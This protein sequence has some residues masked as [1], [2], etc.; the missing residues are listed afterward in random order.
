[1]SDTIPVGSRNS[2]LDQVAAKKA[3]TA[4]SQAEVVD[5]ILTKIYPLLEQP[6]G[7][8]ITIGAAR[9]KA[10]SAWAKEKPPAKK[11]PPTPKT[12]KS[13]SLSPP[14]KSP[15]RPSHRHR[16]RRPTLAIQRQHR[17]LDNRRRTPNRPPR[18][19]PPFTP[20]NA[21]CPPSETPSSKSSSTTKPPSTPAATP[22]G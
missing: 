16:Q 3:A 6:E 13:P 21:T 11:P 12:T 15:N 7:D 2:T 18:R 17:P 22:G 4:N 5:H 1:M 14:P 8:R 10:Q 9:V 20:T 19:P